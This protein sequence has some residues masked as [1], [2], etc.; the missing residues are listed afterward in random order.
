MASAPHVAR[1]VG[2][3][4]RAVFQSTPVPALARTTM[5]PASAAILTAVEAFCVMREAAT[6][7]RFTPVN[8]TTRPT[9]RARA[10]PGGQPARRARYSP[11]TTPIAAMAAQYVPSASTQP[12]TK[13]ACGP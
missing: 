6:E 13:A 9:P 5:S 4:G 8:R 2:A 3:L 7:V 12:T 10:A 1:P 11:L